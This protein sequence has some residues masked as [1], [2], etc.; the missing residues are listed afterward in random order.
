MRE[1]MGHH[2]DRISPCRHLGIRITSRMAGQQTET[3]F[4]TM[5]DSEWGELDE[6]GER[7]VNFFRSEILRPHRPGLRAR[8]AVYHST[9][10]AT[11]NGQRLHAEE[12]SPR[13]NR[14]DPATRPVRYPLKMRSLNACRLELSFHQ[15]PSSSRI[16]R[17]W[18]SPSNFSSRESRG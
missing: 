12:I 7:R 10:R 9:R 15:P 14:L 6:C 3:D 4:G 8:R 17:S 13:A 2:Q 18:F 11:A 16:L 1:P 5:P